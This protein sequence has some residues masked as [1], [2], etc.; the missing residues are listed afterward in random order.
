M[1]MKVDDGYSQVGRWVWYCSW[2]TRE[3]ERIKPA[4]AAEETFAISLGWES[5][6][7]NRVAQCEFSRYRSC[8]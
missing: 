1:R 2:L 8:L 7:H 3:D 5:V 6:K 4:H